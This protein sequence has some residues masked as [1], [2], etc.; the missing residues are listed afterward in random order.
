MF[1]AK[2]LLPSSAFALVVA[3]AGGAVCCATPLVTGDLTIY[4]DFDSFTDTVM[5]GSGNGFNAKVQDGTRTTLDNG[6]TLFTTGVISN[7]AADPKRGAGAVRFAQSEV[8]GDE[9]VFLD[10]DGGVISANAPAKVPKSAITVA[11]WVNIPE[12]RTDI[13]GSGNWNASASILQS[14]S[15]GSSFTTH[16][17]L[18]TDGRV[19]LAL[20]GEFQNQNIVNSSGDPFFTG[21]PWPNQPDV[22]ANGAEPQPF[23]LNEWFHVAFTYDKNASGG[24]NFSMYYNGVKIRSGPPNG[25]TDGLPTGAIDLGAWADRG[26]GDFFDGLGIGSVPDGG[27]ARR[28]HGLMDEFYIFSR[29]LSDAEI[30][31]LAMQNVTLAGDFDEDGDVDGND[32]VVWQRGVGTAYDASDLADWRSNYG[33]GGG[34][35]SSVPEP[36]AAVLCSIVI[37]GYAAGRRAVV[38]NKRRGAGGRSGVQPA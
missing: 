1:T 34:G 8:L 15:A 38:A 31:T 7:D 22:D 4:Y 19:R 32:F 17:Q 2:R 30:G 23:P 26:V 28:L 9:P 33:S 16:Y 21:H 25:L 13:G 5:D 24:G 10:L 20:R 18:E 37:L 29:A 27:G 11:A 3:L 35:I 6:N 12:I 36:T 14:T